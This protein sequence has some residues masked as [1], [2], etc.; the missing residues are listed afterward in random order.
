[1]IL[2]CGGLNS[3]CLIACQWW[4]K[5]LGD[6]PR[7]GVHFNCQHSPNATPLKEHL[8]NDVVGFLMDAAG[9]AP[10]LSHARQLELAYRVQEWLRWPSDAGPCPTPIEARGRRAKQR[11]I[12][13]NLRL[14][15]SVATKKFAYLHNHDPNRLADLIQEGA[16]GLGKGI[17]RF[18]PTLGYSLST[19][20][21]WWIRQ[22][23]QRSAGTLD[24]IY[25]PQY[26]RS[27]YALL[28]RLISDYE[29]QHGERPSLATLSELSGIDEALIRRIIVC[30]SMRVVS[31]DSAANTA[32]GDGSAVGDLIADDHGMSPDDSAV[33]NEKSDLANELLNTLN[34][35]D[36]ALITALFLEDQTL[37]EQSELLGYGVK[38]ISARKRSA[39]K[40]LQIAAGV[41]TPTTKP[42]PCHFLDLN[43][44][45]PWAS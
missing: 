26:V 16:I 3:N 29:A 11:L 44:A 32:D 7:A 30:G 6:W 17:E 1:L 19:Y 12:E 28:N 43:S 41:H 21:Y 31:L 22:S 14:V 15:I 23:I 37:R 24:L 20:C 45:R 34:E 2:L 5:L 4:Q 38:T 35:S 8:S 42:T 13:T 36:R 39:L 33:M 18:N 27:K 25:Q 9:R 10:V 40:R